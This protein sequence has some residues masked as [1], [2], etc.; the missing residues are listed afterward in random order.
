MA[1]YSHPLPRTKR[2]GIQ[3]QIAQAGRAANQAA[4][5]EINSMNSALLPLGRQATG[6]VGTDYRLNDAMV[7]GGIGGLA[8][9]G[10]GAAYGQMTG[11]DRK[12][13]ALLGLVD[14]LMNDP[15]N[16]NTPEMNQA[17]RGLVE[18]ELLGANLRPGA[19]SL[20][21]A[22]GIQNMPLQR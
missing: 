12:R 21:D 9:A 7:G 20:A 15:R 8:G 6:I 18:A 4:A 5:N 17:A 16:P 11:A 3:D 2:A 10:L 22:R 13:Q 14:T 1:Y 19:Q